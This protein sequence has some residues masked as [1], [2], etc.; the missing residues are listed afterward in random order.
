MAVGTRLSEYL[1]DIDFC[2]SGDFLIVLKSGKFCGEEGARCSVLGA[3]GR[4][5]IDGIQGPIDCEGRVVPE[6]GAIADGIIEVGR[7]VEDFG[8]I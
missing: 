2:G 8:A 3:Y 6:D 1:S 7:L 5:P 4:R